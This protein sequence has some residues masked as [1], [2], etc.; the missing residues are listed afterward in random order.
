M[1]KAMIN[2]FSVLNSSHITLLPKVCIVKA[3]IFPAVMYKRV[4]P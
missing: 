2:L 3:M 4:G 1:K